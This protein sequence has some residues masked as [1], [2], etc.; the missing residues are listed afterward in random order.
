MDLNERLDDDVAEP[1]TQCIWDKERYHEDVSEEGGF[2]QHR[3]NPGEIAA[4]ARAECAHCATSMNVQADGDQAC[5]NDIDEESDDA[6]ENG[7]VEGEISS[8]P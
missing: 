4:V 1:M 7:K 6:V 2:D 3:D 8:C 5:Q